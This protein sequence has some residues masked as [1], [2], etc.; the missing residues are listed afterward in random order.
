MSKSVRPEITIVLDRP[1]KLIYDFNALAAYEEATGKNVLAGG[2]TANMTIRDL[3]A[4]IWAGLIADD[5]EL[6]VEQVGRLLHLGNLA[7]VQR[8]V[9]AG[10][11]AAIQT[12]EEGEGDDRPTAEAPS[13]GSISGPSPGTTSASPTPSSGA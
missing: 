10:L 6:T 1:R 11:R 9:F 12:D 13:A 4:L 8:Q 3:R 7:D 2:I 5:P